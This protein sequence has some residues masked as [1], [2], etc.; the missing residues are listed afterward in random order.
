MD[1]IQ[2][3]EKAKD[4]RGAYLA[5]VDRAEGTG[6]NNKRVLLANRQTSMDA[7]NGALF[8]NNEYAYPFDKYASSLHTAYACIKKYRNETA[9]KTMVTRLLGGIR[10]QNCEIITLAKEHVE[11]NFLHDWHAATS[12][13]S[14]KIAKVFPPRVGGGKRR[15]HEQGGRRI[16]KVTRGGDRGRGRGGRF[17]RGGGR[18][19]RGG[20]RDG[21]RGR[22][23]QGRGRGE[24]FRGSHWNGVDVRDHTRDFTD[25]EMS[26]LGSNGRRHIFQRRNAD[27]ADRGQKGRGG[28]DFRQ[29][30]QAG[31]GGQRLHGGED[32]TAIVPYRGEQDADN[33][34]AQHRAATGRG[35]QAGSGFGRG[36]YGGRGGRGGRN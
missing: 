6:A 18:G 31:T 17:N 4:G 22:G 7:N 19:G 29:I 5:I 13:L 2:E 32:S 35:G 21:G 36:A 16:S 1:W 30:Q 33:T 24:N 14:T 20:G 23:Y 10:V 26:R 15:A 3:F 8:Y 28:N 25:E 9:T 27:W 11:D 12:H 34:S